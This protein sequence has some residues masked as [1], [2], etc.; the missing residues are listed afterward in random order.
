MTQTRRAFLSTLPAVLP[1]TKLQRPAAASRLG[2]AV[3]GV[4]R[5]ARDWILPALLHH[6]T[7]CR[8]AGLIEADPQH[9]RLL[10]HSLGLPTECLM[11]FED[12]PQLASQEAI[13][14]VYVASPTSLHPRHA[15]A[16]LAAGKHVICR[17]PMAPSSGACRAMIDAAQRQQRLLVVDY[18]LHSEPHVQALQRIV[19]QHTMGLTT[20][21][22]SL[23]GIRRTSIDDPDVRLDTAGPYPLMNLAVFGIQAA[24]YATG[25]V[26]VT[27]ESAQL[28][29]MRPQIF[30]SLPDTMTWTLRFADGATAS[31]EATFTRTQNQLRVE[32]Q[33]GVVEMEPAFTMRGIQSRI[34]GTLSGGSTTNLMAAF[35]DHVAQTLLTNARPTTPGE[36]GLRDVAIIEAIFSAAKIKKP[37]A[38]D[39]QRLSPSKTGRP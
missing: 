9:A 31:G 12:M 29:T 21:V 38:I 34:N 36:M 4:G 18:Q 14:A 24:C 17:K 27:V 13:D 6:S 22:R 20:S 23:I 8:L 10:G 7:R 35:L 25:Q 3:C 15:I 11:G 5:Y 1:L 28:I 16:A 33:R 19:A 2:I 37:V 32:M 30:G 26:P 39:L